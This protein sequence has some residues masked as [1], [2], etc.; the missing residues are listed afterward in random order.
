MRSLGVCAILLALAAI[1][2]PADLRGQYEPLWALGILVLLA[3]TL[4]NSLGRLRLPALAGWLTAGVILGPAGF[5]V[6]DLTHR[7]MLEISGA[8]AGL[9]AGLLVGLGASWPVGRRDWRL[10]AIVAAST[11]ATWG[12]LSAAIGLVSDLPWTA[13][14][15]FAALAC[16]WGPVVSDF[17][18]NR[19]TQI[20]GL[21]GVGVGVVLL[22][23]VV[24]VSS[25]GEV[26]TADATGW[27]LRLLASGGLG[28]V[29]AEL[30]WRLRL[31][32][33]R[34][35][36]LL[37]LAAVSLLGAIAA[38][39]VGLPVLPLGLGA[40]LVLAAREGTGRQLGHL[41]APARSMAILLFA[42]F[43][44]ASTDAAALLWP[45]IP[46]VYEIVVAQ[47]VVLV[48]VRGIGPALW[49]PLPASGEF[50]RRSGWLLLPKGL[51]AG[52]L[53]L[54][55]GEPLT[56]FLAPAYADLLRRVVVA[57]LFVY[58]LVFA[59]LA[60]FVPPRRS[61]EEIAVD[62]GD[63]DAPVPA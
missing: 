19:E 60:A 42:A 41:L 17:W 40:G 5:D 62:D 59:S 50:S 45:A 21:F 15:L 44:A 25:G 16:M 39:H 54:G 33:R 36:A 22:G 3:L 27:A 55:P 49:Y 4:Q 53:I 30:L 8:V 10:P 43:L 38:V 11:V 12:L 32:E 20:I 14:P 29:A 7:P 24:A 23:A 51:I 28:A 13:V 47:L 56:T 9:W 1:A 58:A 46:G 61:D 6:V 63:V 31:L 2:P 26:V 34:D 52:E 57:D 37:V 48:L 18:R 35:S